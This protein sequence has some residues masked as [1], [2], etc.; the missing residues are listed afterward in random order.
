[1]CHYVSYPKF[2]HVNMFR[3]P[4]K[5]PFKC[6]IPLYNPFRPGGRNVNDRS[7]PLKYKYVRAND[8]PFMT[9]ELRNAVMLRS[10][11]RNRFNRF[12]TATAEVAYKRQRNICT[13]LFRK[14]KSDYYCNLNPFSITDNKKFWK[15]VKPLFSEKIMST[16][17]ITIISQIFS[18]FFSNVVNNTPI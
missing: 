15:N 3:T 13:N 16:E 14:A 6:F 7:L 4:S 5:C 17:G 11:L 2:H 12:K 18:H 10:R 8:S 1:M 9:K